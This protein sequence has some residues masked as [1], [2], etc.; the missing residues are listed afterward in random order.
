MAKEGMRLIHEPGSLADVET[1]VDA[2]TAYAWALAYSVSAKCFLFSANVQDA[3][4]SG[5]ETET[6]PS[7]GLPG[8]AHPFHF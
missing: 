5:R 3:M 4:F 7:P 8:V 1:R 2:L 6:S